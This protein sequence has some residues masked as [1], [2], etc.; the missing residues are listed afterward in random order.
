VAGRVLAD[1]VPA[2][3]VGDPRRG[4]VPENGREPFRE[5]VPVDP[6]EYRDLDRVLRERVDGRETLV[7]GRVEARSDD[8]QRGRG[9]RDGA[10]ARAGRQEEDEWGQARNLAFRAPRSDVARMPA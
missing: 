9:R 5:P 7:Q 10:V 1:L 6:L 8:R 2:E 4:L 3:R